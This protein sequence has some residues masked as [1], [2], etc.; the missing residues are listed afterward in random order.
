V[1]VN[2]MLRKKTC[3]DLR[4]WIY[5]AQDTDQWQATVNTVIP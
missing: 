5:L 2:R 1:S 4:D 3:L